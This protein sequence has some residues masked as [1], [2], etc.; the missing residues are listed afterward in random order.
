MI[1]KRVILVKY[2]EI[3]WD[4]TT[5]REINLKNSAIKIVFTGG[6]TIIIPTSDWH[7]IKQLATF[8]NCTFFHILEHCVP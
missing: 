7:K 8:P 6:C 3:I 2:R 5:Q 4:D 1:L